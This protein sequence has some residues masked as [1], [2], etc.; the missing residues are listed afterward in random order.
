MLLKEIFMI[1][2][3]ILAVRQN[4]LKTVSGAICRMYK[5]N[6]RSG[7]IRKFYGGTRLFGV[8][9]IAVNF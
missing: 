6:S 9:F 1:I 7:S 8:Q 4:L 5:R 2:T 3:S